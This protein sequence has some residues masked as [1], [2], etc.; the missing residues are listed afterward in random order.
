MGDI[1]TPSWQSGACPD[2]CTVEHAEQDHPD[3]RSHRDDGIAVPVAFRIRRFVGAELV[4]EVA[5]G[6]LVLGRWQRDG[7]PRTWYLLGDDNGTELELSEESF[8]RLVDSMQ[9]LIDGPPAMR[10]QPSPR[11]S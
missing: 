11:R 4:E 6:H 2:W 1:G 3:D 7:D 10:A 8:R 5:Q 9:R